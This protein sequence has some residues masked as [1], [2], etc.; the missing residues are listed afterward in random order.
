MEVRS[1][2]L[3][4]RVGVRGYCLSVVLTPSPGA[5]PQPK[6]CFGVLFRSTAAKAAYA[7]P[8]G[9]GEAECVDTAIQ[10]KIIPL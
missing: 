6:R 4:E 2:S 3:W 8:H 1:L 10:L 7:S 9:R 5:L